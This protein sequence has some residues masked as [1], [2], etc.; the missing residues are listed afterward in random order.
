[1]NVLEPYFSDSLVRALGWTF[2]HSLW[3]GALA[4]AAFLCAQWLLRFQSPQ[5][6]YL[7]G[8]LSLLL[9]L[10]GVSAT[11]VYSYRKSAAGDFPTPA[12]G[13]FSQS[14]AGFAGTFGSPSSSAEGGE[15]S[16]LVALKNNYFEK[17]HSLLVGGWIAG[18][19]FLCLRHIGAY[20]YTNRLRRTGLANPG[21]DLLQRMNRLLQRSGLAG[22][23]S[24]MESLLVDAPM[25]IGYFKPVILLPVGLS[26]GLSLQ[27]LEAILA[28]EIA[29]IRR[30]DF[31]VNILQ[32]FVETLFFYH[33]AVWLI[34]SCIRQERENCCDDL[35]LQWCGDKMSLVKA[36]A[37]AEEWRLNNSLALGFPGTGN[38]LLNRIKRIIN[39]KQMKTQSNKG[40]F[41]G[42]L[43]AIALVAGL[44]LTTLTA[45]KGVDTSL[46]S[47][48]EKA[49]AK[50]SDSTKLQPSARTI[51]GDK[52]KAEATVQDVAE[53]VS[54]SQSQAAPKPLKVAGPAPAAD[55]QSAQAVDLDRGR[56]IDMAAP[57]AHPGIAAVAGVNSMAA[58][59]PFPPAGS[60]LMHSLDTAEFDSAFRFSQQEFARQ[61][62]RFARDMAAMQSELGKEMAERAAE[63][64]RIAAEMAR[65]SVPFD[66][67][68]MWKHGEELARHQQDMATEQAEMARLHA[69][70]GSPHT[71][72]WKQHE[73]A[74]RQQ[75]TEMR[76][77]ERE[78]RNHEK[79]AKAF[80][81]ALRKELL[82]D[83]LITSSTSRIHLKIT[84]TALTVNGEKQSDELYR[85][86]R[87]LVRESWDNSLSADPSPDEEFTISFSY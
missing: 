39:N 62:E 30:H 53:P 36:L 72:E 59:P 26:T 58:F 1:M 35:A 70:M 21:E 87:R 69:E 18:I 64:S 73:E 85:K 12:S 27:E 66:G 32:V 56:T 28:H 78:L 63:M 17:Y 8:L 42:N 80:E 81:E 37:H 46:L 2:L 84:G 31:L 4:G 29:H 45:L 82:E 77:M 74:L 44:C 16:W 52:N 3:I 40:I 5:K 11:F 60:F 22:K 86:Y 51:T 61:M 24:L 79:K 10:A 75:E 13:V 20:F 6:R 49:V 33:P 67:H 43:L 15:D 54:E 34:G 68:E 38:S 55:V 76:K 83:G 19:V 47:G 41:M 65:A 48:R 50:Q 71:E 57:A 7:A 25:V 14:D 23:V 9:L